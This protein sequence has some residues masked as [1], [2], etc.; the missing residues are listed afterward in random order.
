MI[1]SA[2]SEDDYPGGSSGKIEGDASFIEDSTFKGTIEGDAVVAP[3]VRLKVT[4]KIRGSLTLGP[5]AFAEVAGKIGGDVINHGGTFR[6]KG[7]IDGSEKHA[8]PGDYAGPMARP[9]TSVAMTT[10]STANEALEQASKQNKAKIWP[11]L[12]GVLGLAC[13][14]MVVSAVVWAYAGRGDGHN[15]VDTHYRFQIRTFWIGLLYVF[16]SL[17]TAIVIIGLLFL[18]ILPFWVLI[19]CIR[20]WRYLIRGAPHPKPASWLF[21]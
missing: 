6:L 16:V 4:G 10:T 19:R 17:A 18:A 12:S 5:D 3:G 7:K 15:W 2:L 11:Y 20:G 21:G 8:P 13:A 1:F 9:S 14:V